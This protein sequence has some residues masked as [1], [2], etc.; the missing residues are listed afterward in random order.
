MKKFKKQ[1]NT[2]KV[3]LFAGATA[4][5]ALTQNTHAQTSVD[6]LLNKLEQKG[7]LTVDEARELKS[8][9]ATNSVN[10]FNTALGS[11]FPMPDWVTGYKLSGDFRGRYDEQTSGNPVIVDRDRLRYR[12]R[13]GLT[14]NMKD[15]LE[16]GFRVGSGDASKSTVAALAGSQGNN[17]NGNPL[18]NNQTFGD[19][20][21]KKPL[22][23]DMAYG[24][25]T[26]INDGTLMASA[27][28]G[29]MAQPFDASPMVFDPDYTPEGGALQASY[30]FSDTQSVRFNSAAFV[31]D[32]NSATVHDPFLFGGQ[33]ILDSKWTPALSTSLGVA[34]YDISSKG[35][36]AT[37][38]DSNLGNTLNGAGNSYY[39]GA[40]LINNYNP[41]VVSGNITYT[42][43]SFPLY[44]GAFPIKLSGE[45]M[46]NPAATASN[47]GYWGGL[48]LGKSGKKGAWD[49]SYRYQVLESDAWWDQVVDDDNVAAFTSL[50]NAAGL[51]GGTNIKGH[52][53]KFNY[54]LTDALTFTFTCYVNNLINNPFPTAN[55]DAIHAMADI[56]WKF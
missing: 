11:K 31:L 53:V 26:A 10:D 33:I 37:T 24:K 39:A 38:Y 23:V 44:T 14:V 5:M 32:E 2:T 16:V 47:L 56:M 49:V 52:L 6:A 55:T 4:L 18:S 19:D 9:N 25:W 8:E 36:L 45:Y 1:N 35:S 15:N 29:K 34:A 17:S 40:A 43:D 27:T 12:L 7:V 3:A 20:A 46:E 42:L 13:V 21:S 22:Y 48:M 28:F 50:G 30:K 41:F 54:S 51:A